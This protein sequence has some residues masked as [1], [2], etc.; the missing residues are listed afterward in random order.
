[1]KASA[2]PLTPHELCALVGV[3]DVVF[4]LGAARRSVPAQHQ[5]GP[6]RRRV[7]LV[8][9]TREGQRQEDVDEDM[10]SSRH[11]RSAST[12]RALL[13]SRATLLTGAAATPTRALV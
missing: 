4:A 2:S 6:K 7:C 9:V 13:R 1:M 8:K 11:H 10:L 12:V 5:A 3:V